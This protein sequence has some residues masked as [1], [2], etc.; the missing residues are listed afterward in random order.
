MVDSS[1]IIDVQSFC[2]FLSKSWSTW[3]SRSTYQEAAHV[4]T[5]TVQYV[6]AFI[7]D[8]TIS[9]TDRAGKHFFSTP[10]KTETRNRRGLR[11][12]QSA[13]Y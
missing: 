12:F 5:A 1:W 3:L 13:D 2:F 8:A 4:R 7:D 10:P 6:L 11:P 9:S